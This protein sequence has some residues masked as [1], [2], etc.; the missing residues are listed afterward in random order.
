M[1]QISSRWMDFSEILYWDFQK[2]LSINSRF[3]SDL[4]KYWAFYI[5][6]QV[7][8]HFWQQK[9]ISCS[10]TPVQRKPIIVFPWKNTRGFVLSIATM[11]ANNDTKRRRYCFQLQ[12]WLHE[13]VTLCVTRTLP[14][15]S[16]LMHETR[17]RVRKVTPGETCGVHI[18]Y[19]FF[20]CP[21][22]PNG[23]RHHRRWHFEIIQS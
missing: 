15:L 21:T 22:A 9:K 12:Q 11:Y 10:S 4:K 17:M 18:S 14:I 23:P 1:C 3:G 13:R 2:N 5:K 19:N 7:I 16:V 8:L 6:A 20:I